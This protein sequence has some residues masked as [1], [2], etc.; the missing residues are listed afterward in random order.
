MRLIELFREHPKTIGMSYLGHMVRALAF[1]FMLFYAALLCLI[2]AF[3]PFLFEHDAS[4]LVS[5]I[6]QKMEA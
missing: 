5:L 4:N 6:K 2:H 1:S 3:F